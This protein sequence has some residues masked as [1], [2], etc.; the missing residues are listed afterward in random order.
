MS[1]N[2][3][4]PV[5]TLAL[6]W[7]LGELSGMLKSRSARREELRLTIFRIITLLDDMDL[8]LYLCNQMPLDAVKAASTQRAEDVREQLFL[9]WS[10]QQELIQSKMDAVITPIARFDPILAYQLHDA[11]ITVRSLS[12]PKIS[13]G[14]STLTNGE[15]IAFNTMRQTLSVELQRDLESMLEQLA[16]RVGPFTTKR[17]RLLLQGRTGTD[18]FHRAEEIMTK[19]KD[20]VE[21]ESEM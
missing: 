7:F 9:R 11:L 8:F 4:W 19:M 15:I 5:I 3:I 16:R 2:A 12:K 20:A 13:E 6:G 17:V 1:W 14:Q 10:S 21:R 18:G